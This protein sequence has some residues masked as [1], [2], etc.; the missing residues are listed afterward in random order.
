MLLVRRDIVVFCIAGTILVL[1]VFQFS[2]FF[3]PIV[4]VFIFGNLAGISTDGLPSPLFYCG[5]N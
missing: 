3:P 4:F 2:Q 5:R 1:F